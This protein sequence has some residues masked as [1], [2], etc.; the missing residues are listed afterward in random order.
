IKRVIG[1]GGDVV[2]CCDS[3]GR[4]TVNGKG[5]DEPYVYENDFREFGPITVPD[6]DLWLMGDHRSRSSDSR[7]NGPVPQ[8]KV[9]GRAFVR[10]WPIGRS[11]VLSVPGTFSDVPS[12]AGASAPTPAAGQTPAAAGPLGSLDAL[13]APV[14]A[15]ALVI[16]G[17]RW[18]GSRRRGRRRRGTGGSP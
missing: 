14:A 2:A 5:L 13:L 10:V 15:V 7:Q 4:V 17:R 16:P 11:G 1:V 8:D 9:I 18:R 12:A 6:G 3:A